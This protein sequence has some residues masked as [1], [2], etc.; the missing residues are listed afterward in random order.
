MRHARTFPAT[1]IVSIGL[2]VAV[3]APAA[4]AQQRAP[5]KTPQPVWQQV[6]LTSGRVRGL[7]RDEVGKGI[8]GVSIAALG[9]TSMVVQTDST[10]RF[11]LPLPSGEY[12]LMAH[13]EGYVSTYRDLV[14]VRPS[15]SLE[16]TITMTKAAPARA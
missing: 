7:V 11:V 8:S 1:T 12:V 16:R 9:T 5:Y 15:T 14:M 13:R 3:S 6:S 2:L 10:G 4:F